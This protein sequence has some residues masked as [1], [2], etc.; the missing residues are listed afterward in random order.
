MQTGSV[1]E[2]QFVVRIATPDDAVAIARIHNQGISE[3]IATF[4]TRGPHGSRR[5]VKASRRKQAPFPP[6]SLRRTA[7]LS[8]GR[9]LVPTVAVPAITAS[10]STPCMSS[11]PIGTRGW[12]C[13]AT[14]ARARLPTAWFLETGLAHLP[15]EHGESGATCDPRIPSSRRLSPA[16]ATRWRMEGLRH[17]GKL[18][19]RPTNRDLHRLTRGITG[20]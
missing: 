6:S 16:R 17:R 8:A 11:K 13:G 4:E 12:A 1:A 20:A 19:V 10:P 3:R 2:F 14:R 9:L 15:G 5:S 7:P 18:L